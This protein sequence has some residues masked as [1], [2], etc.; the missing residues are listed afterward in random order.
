[1]KRKTIAIAVVSAAF[2]GAASAATLSVVSVAGTW[3]N[4][5]PAGVA[6]GEGTSNLRWGRPLEADNQSGYDFAASGPFP[7]SVSTGEDFVL[8]RFTHRNWPIGGRFLTGANLDLSI[9]IERVA[10]PFTSTISFGHNE[11][12]NQQSI[13]PVGGANR[14]GINAGGCADIVDVQGD[15]DGSRMFEVDGESVMLDLVGFR[16]D[17][18]AQGE[19][20]TAEAQQNEAELVGR[21]VSLT[22]G[23]TEGDAGEGGTPEDN[24]DMADGGSGGDMPTGDASGGDVAVPAVV[25]LPA[26]AW[27]LMGAVAGLGALRRFRA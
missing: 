26:G 16:V 10:E 23:A 19:F 15:I 8:G 7:T 9:E 14:Q 22:G 21:F 27:L 12:D 2:G 24:G 20:V 4:A 25:P 11:T 1:M 13:C 18:A 5:T 6:T 17:G 3:S